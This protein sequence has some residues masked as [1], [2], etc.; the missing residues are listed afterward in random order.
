MPSAAAQRLRSES[1]KT[2]K[3]GVSYRF[4]L[5]ANIS[6]VHFYPSPYAD[7]DLRN[8]V[9]TLEF[10]QRVLDASR[11]TMYTRIEQDRS[12]VYTSDDSGA[13]T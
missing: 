8:G 10:V 4:S 3:T 12:D 9:S 11:R 1:R 13:K 2:N 7:I 5:R 6:I